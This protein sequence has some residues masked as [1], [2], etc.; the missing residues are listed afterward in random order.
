MGVGKATGVIDAASRLVQGV[1][2]GLSRVSAI[3]SALADLI[4]SRWLEP[5]GM[6]AG[7]QVNGSV[8]H[9]EQQGVRAPK[10]GH[11]QDVSG[12][13]EDTARPGCGPFPPQTSP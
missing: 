3:G 12:Q 8:S 5:T 1:D 4:V 13:L 11:G 2:M 6:A 10:L 7:V 9:T